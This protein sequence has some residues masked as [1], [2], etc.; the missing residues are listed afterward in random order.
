MH[1]ASVCQAPLAHADRHDA[2]A[3][4]TGGTTCTSTNQSIVTGQPGAV[5]RRTRAHV[6]I[7][8]EGN[9]SAGLPPREACWDIC[10]DPERAEPGRRERH[11]LRDNC[12]RN[13]RQGHCEQRGGGRASPS[14]PQSDEAKPGAPADPKDEV[15]EPE[16]GTVAG[17]HAIIALRYCTLSGRFED[18]WEWRPSDGGRR[19]L[20]LTQSPRSLPRCRDTTSMS[21]SVVWN[22]STASSRET[23]T[24][25][26]LSGPSSL[27]AALPKR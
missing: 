26:S 8:R 4:S 19:D 23:A 18:F 12:Q 7:V 24:S 17:A 9:Y 1:L 20:H 27:L 5:T 21:A 25:M 22:A 14:Q 13:A 3:G 6:T 16:F 10:A 15:R 11:Q 2:R